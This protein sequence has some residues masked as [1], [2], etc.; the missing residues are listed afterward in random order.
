MHSSVQTKAYFKVL[1]KRR[2]LSVT[3]ETNLLRAAILPVRDCTSLIVFGEEILRMAFTFFGFTSIP[4]YDTMKPGN[5]PEDTPKAHLAG[6]SFILYF[7]SVLN[8]SLR[9]SK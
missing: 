7:L 4:F 8:V 5:F 1:K 6:F 2:H 9:S 3:L